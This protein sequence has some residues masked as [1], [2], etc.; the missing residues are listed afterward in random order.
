ME[1]QVTKRLTR[2]EKIAQGL[3][4][5]EGN[6]KK[7]SADARKEANKSKAFASLKKYPSSPRKMR[8]LADLVRGQEVGHALNLLYLSSKSASKPLEKLLR[9][10]LNNFTQKFPDTDIDSNTLVVKEVFVDGGAMLKRIR[11]APQGRA[12][13]VRKRSNHVTIVVDT[14]SKAGDT[15]ITKTDS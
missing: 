4:K 15:T 7:R 11:P 9:S 5:P 12:Y 14:A 8:L 2:K 10:A 3:P 1:A 13:R 6:R